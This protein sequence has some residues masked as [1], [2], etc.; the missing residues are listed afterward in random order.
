SASAT[1]HLMVVPPTSTPTYRSAMALAL[2]QFFSHA[3]QQLLRQPDS[4]ELVQGVTF[5]L[6]PDEPVVVVIE[7]DFHHPPIVGPRFIAVLVKIVRLGADR[8]GKGHHLFDA[9][10]SV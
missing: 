1:A 8:L 4:L 10:I 5:I 2:G 7:H 6:D 9:F 3:F